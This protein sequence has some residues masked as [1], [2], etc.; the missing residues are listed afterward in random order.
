MTADTIQILTATAI[1]KKRTK[2]PTGGGRPKGSSKY[3]FV[4]LPVSA[5]DNCPYFQFEAKN[6]P[7]ASVLAARGAKI[8][9]GAKFTARA[10]LNEDG[11]QK[12]SESGKPLFGCWRVK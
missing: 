10:L 8:V 6:G 3:P 9:P 11:T 7:A 4:T 1:P 2:P 12:V 5:G